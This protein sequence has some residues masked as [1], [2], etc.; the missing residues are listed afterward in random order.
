MSSATV[1]VSLSSWS[2]RAF[3]L[4]MALL[5]ALTRICNKHLVV[6]NSCSSHNLIFRK[7]LERLNKR[8]S[9]CAHEN[10]KLSSKAKAMSLDDFIA[11]NHTSSSPFHQRK[12]AELQDTCYNTLVSDTA[13]SSFFSLSWEVALAVALFSSAW[14]LSS[15]SSSC[16]RSCSNVWA[17]L[18]HSGTRKSRRSNLSFYKPYLTESGCWFTVF[19]LPWQLSSVFVS[20][21]SSVFLQTAKKN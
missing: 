17:Q 10:S 20:P 21:G 9:L 2:T 12:W 18:S 4:L 1:T 5:N 7:N 3:W 6:F 16:S 8:V 13:F 11:F 15:S 19:Y 14:T